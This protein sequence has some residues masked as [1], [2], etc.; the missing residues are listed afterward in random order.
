MILRPRFTIWDRAGVSSGTRRGSR[1]G[2]PRRRVAGTWY[3]TKQLNYQR[4]FKV[5]IRGC[6]EGGRARGRRRKIIRKGRRRETKDI[7]EGY[8]EE[9]ERG[10]E[11]VRR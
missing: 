6:A 11:K 2:N 10:K 7:K 4:L 9:R 3:S 5:E 8:D 1:E